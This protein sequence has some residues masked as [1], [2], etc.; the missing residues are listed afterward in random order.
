MHPA[1][2]PAILELHQRLARLGVPTSPEILVPRRAFIIER[3][4]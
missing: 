1:K 3:G 2:L 4:D